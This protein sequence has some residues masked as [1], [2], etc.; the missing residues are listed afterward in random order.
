MGVQLSSGPYGQETGIGVGAV[1]ESDKLETE[2]GEVEK[3]EYMA[4]KVRLPPI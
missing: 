1:E 4:K 3:V 2:T